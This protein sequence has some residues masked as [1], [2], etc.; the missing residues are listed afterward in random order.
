MQPFDIIGLYCFSALE[1]AVIRIL[2][3]L[4]AVFMRCAIQKHLANNFP[5]HQAKPE[6]PGLPVAAALGGMIFPAAIYL[7]FNSGSDAAHG[8]G[9][10]MATDIAFALAALSL[11]RNNV[12]FG[13]RIFLSAILG[14]SLLYFTQKT[15]NP[16][17]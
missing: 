10:P 3:V 9:I 11:L 8:W 7:L 1:F 14:L 6:M 2:N 13:V 16:A 5:V 12:P 4:D 15:E 17:A